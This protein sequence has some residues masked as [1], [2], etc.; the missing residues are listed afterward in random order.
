[1][2]DLI[3]LFG[4]GII[5]GFLAGLLGIGGGPIYVVLFSIFIPKLYGGEITE[6]QTI[7]LI[8]ANTVFARFFAALSGCWKHYR[9]NNLYLKTAIAIAIPA[10]MMSLI[11]ISILSK[12]NYNKT[13]FSIIF[14]LVF[15]PL[16]YRM[17]VDDKNKKNFNHPYRIK[18]LFLNMTGLISGTV[19][20][21]A[22]LGGGFVVVPLLNSLFN[23]KI[24]KVV[25]IS[26]SVISMVAF[27]VTVFYLSQYKV[28]INDP[29]IFGAISLSLCL[30]VI[31]GV[32]FAAP[33]GVKMSNQVSPYKLRVLFIAFCVFIIAKTL[34]FDLFLPLWT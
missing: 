22:G 34:I 26:L 4:G 23:I 15:I 28:D 19:T 18:V 30:P 6:A 21:L 1:M 33:W 27:S 29:Y 31:A 12:M 16:L 20:A 10:A 14:I 9:M 13:F 11:G 8:I 5:G 25:S 3:C 24:K 17:I 7:Q 32:M 2:L